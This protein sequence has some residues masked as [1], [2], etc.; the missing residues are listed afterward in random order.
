MQILIACAK[1]MSAATLPQ[2]VSFSEPAFKG[3][4]GELALQLA[5]YSVDELGKMLHVNRSIAAENYLRY[6]NFHDSSTRCP[7][8]SGYDGMVFRKFDAR[9]MSAADLA[10][11][12]RHLLIG[13]FLYGLLRP[14]DLIN[15]YRLEGSVALPGNGHKTMFDFWKPLLTDRFIEWVKADDGILVNLASSEFRDILDW[16]RVSSELTVITP[17]FKVEKDGRMRTV[18]IY[19]KMCRGAMAR[20]I[21]I[22]RI[23]DPL[24]LRSFE[25]EGFSHDNG[26]LFSLH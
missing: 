17:E 6:C 11:A 20:W 23:S 4:A 14:L 18:V 19:A 16:K 1:T 13:S 26:W 8:I 24:A 21:I 7:A 9:S 22:N 5:G 3:I 15:P 2:T 25:Y 12:Q 10:Y